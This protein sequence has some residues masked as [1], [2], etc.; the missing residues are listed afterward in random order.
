M[1][2][3]PSGLFTLIDLM[4][5]LK[6][7][8]R[9]NSAGTQSYKITFDKAK[10]IIIDSLAEKA[11][12]HAVH[13]VYIFFDSRA[14]A[15]YVGKTK[16]RFDRRL[17]GHRRISGRTVKRVIALIEVVGGKGVTVGKDE[18]YIIE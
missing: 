4:T 16:N 3:D 9:N 17:Q 8:L 5:S 14:N 11:I 13:G 7:N 10:C 1:G 12:E 15:P 6:E 2:T 18:L